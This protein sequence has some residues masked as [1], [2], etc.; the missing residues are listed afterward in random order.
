MK[1]VTGIGGIFFHAKDPVALRAWYQRHL[2]IDV[3]TWGGAAFTWTDDA[4]QPTGGS[5]IWSINAADGA[6]FAPG[7]ASFMVNYRVDDLDALLAVLR[8]EGCQ[9]LDK[10]DDSDYGKFG[11]VIDPEGNKVELWQ[12]PHGQ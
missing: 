8:D 3:Q 11:W 1:R 2:G 7:Q 10:A 9:V 12:P 5:T 6:P 4:G